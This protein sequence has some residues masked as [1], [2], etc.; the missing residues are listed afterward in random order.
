M[1]SLVN[2]DLKK[3][4]KKSELVIG[5]ELLVGLECKKIWTTINTK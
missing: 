1:V 4:E 2:L 3:K 5:K